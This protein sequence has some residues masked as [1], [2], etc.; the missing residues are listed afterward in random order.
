M[1]ENIEF[2]IND[3]KI[4]LE[5]VL[6]RLDWSLPILFVC[7]DENKQRYL[8]MCLDSNGTEV[9]LAK[10]GNKELYKMIKG[11]ITMRNIFEISEMLWKIKVGESFQ[12]DMCTSIKF[13]EL[14]E[15]ELPTKDSYYEIPNKEIEDFTEQLINKI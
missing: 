8:A 7:I 13:Y 6:V 4:L 3:H 14:E 15:D 11:N 2:K 12:E 9:L 5:K 10:V 1:E